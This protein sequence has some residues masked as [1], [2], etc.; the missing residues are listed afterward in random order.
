MNDFDTTISIETTGVQI[1]D[2]CPSRHGI[3]TLSNDTYIF[4]PVANDDTFFYLESEGKKYPIERG[5]CRD[6][7]NPN[8]LNSINNL[9]LS[10][11]KVIF[12]YRSDGKQAIVYTPDE[13][14]HQ[15]PRALA[16]LEAN[17]QVL[18]G[19]DKGK[20]NNYPQWYAFGRTQ[21]LIM[22]RFKLFF[23][24]F[25]NKPIRC[26]ICDA[27]DLMLYNGM[28]FVNSDERKLKILKAVIESELFWGYIQSNAKPYSSG[29]YSL[30]GV[31]IRHFGIPEFSEEEEEELLAMDDKNKL[32]KWLR[33]RYGITI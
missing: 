4:M 10:I 18:L 24:K 1:K 31:D 12:P 25:A 11:E 3:A 27:P 30:S 28:A 29:Y 15:Y 8:K 22:P 7:V 13:M 21:S 19:R 23:P 16:Y 9:N 32:E 5:I 17:K 20:T 33:G 2:Y 14:K 26:I 6:I